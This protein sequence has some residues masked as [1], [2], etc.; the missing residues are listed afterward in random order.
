M[1]SSTRALHKQLRTHGLL[2]DKEVADQ[3]GTALDFSLSAMVLEPLQDKQKRLE[4]NIFD[5]IIYT[6]QPFAIV[7]D[8]SF[9]RMLQSIS[10]EEDLVILSCRTI[11]CCII[12]REGSLAH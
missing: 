12:E 6:L 3:A 9:A 7:E 10:D 5:W 11:R 2:V 8:P 1:S 4:L